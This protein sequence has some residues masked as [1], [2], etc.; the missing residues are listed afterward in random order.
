M[1]YSSREEKNMKQKILL[2]AFVGV[3][4]LSLNA[5]GGAPVS[6][7]TSQV[8]VVNTPVAQSNTLTITSTNAFTDSYGTYHVV[9]EVLNN[10]SAVVSSIELTVEIKDTAGN[11]LIKDDSGNV[12]ANAQ[13]SPMLY[14]LAPGEA[15][16]F[17]Y[18]YETTQGTPASFNVTISGQQTGTVNR[19]SLNTENV[20]LVDDGQ[21]WYYLTGEL[22]NTGSQWAHINSMAGAV[23]DDTNHILSADWT[24]T[25]ATEVAPAGDA[26]GRD[27]TPFEIN[28]P[29]PGGATKWHVYLDADVSDT[30]IDYP[31][32]VTISNTY[33]DQYGSFHVVGWLANN[34]DKLLD[35]LVVAGV[36]GAD[37]T[38]LDSSYSFVPV[39]VKPG[40]NA[41]F[42]VSSFSSINYNPNQASLVDT[43][44]IQ[45]DPWFTYPP[46]N[47]VV[48]LAA[49]GETI[50]KN[51]ATWTFDGSVT[52]TSDKS[53][54]GATVVVMITDVQNKLIAMEYTSISP[55]GDAIAP[56]DSNPYSVSIYLDPKAN[57][58]GLT[59]ST[60]VIGDV[61]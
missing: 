38:V 26:A 40:A 12:A 30:V 11:S 50:T 1:K 54:S 37:K 34:S 47:D 18:S 5:C 59:T 21:G 46:T 2:C 13:V 52:N 51:G 48:D 33:F 14:T 10:S 57:T 41:A 44:S 3:L 36:Y 61:K 17:E 27:R 16:P 24:A 49:T 42:S 58:T 45:A 60:V 31:L 56:G 20:Q 32:G 6:T 25:Y 19:A 15:S 23:L 55:S 43:T 39:P 8:P 35:S 4:I 9:G 22:V 53:L 28:F 7:P 29:N